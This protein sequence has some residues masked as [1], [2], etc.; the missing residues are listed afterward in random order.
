MLRSLLILPVLLVVALAAG[1]GPSQTATAPSTGGA[2]LSL[3][4]RE[5]LWDKEYAQVYVIYPKGAQPPSGD[6]QLERLKPLL[7]DAKNNRTAIHGQGYLRR[8]TLAPVKDVEG[9]G[10][11]FPLGRVVAY[12]PEKRALLVEYGK[13]PAARETWRDAAYLEHQVTAWQARGGLESAAASLGRQMPEAEVV[14]VEVRAA[15]GVRMPENLPARFQALLDGPEDKRTVSPEQG[16]GRVRSFAAG[17]VKDLPALA[18][19]VEFARV[20]LADPEVRVLVLEIE[21]RKPAP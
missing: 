1:C 4:E 10:Q 15:D 20:V 12:A 8:I 7:D 18:K 6:A 2:S 11:K 21:G 3:T 5:A 16:D 9:L 19:K 14:C 13:D 17:P